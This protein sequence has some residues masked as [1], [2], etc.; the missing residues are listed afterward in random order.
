M[1]PSFALR[2][3]LAIAVVKSRHESKQET[4]SWRKRSTDWQQAFEKS[5]EEV[6]GLQSQIKSLQQSNEEK[7]QII[8]DLTACVNTVQHPMECDTRHT[9]SFQD[10]LAS[11]S[12][13]WGQRPDHCGPHAPG[14]GETSRE[15]R[16]ENTEK[17][18]S[19][20]NTEMTPYISHQE[21][22]VRDMSALQ[23]RCMAIAL[24]QPGWTSSLLN[25]V[26]F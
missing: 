2:D 9:Q 25:T 14:A 10:T 11:R 3:L 22:V 1:A 19:N 20:H 12:Q 24:L 23:Y 6:A 15:Q 26:T 21:A 18:K 4:A 17:Y 13:T 5:R 7:N 16:K 8:Q